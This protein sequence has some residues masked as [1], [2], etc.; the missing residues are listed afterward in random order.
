MQEMLLFEEIRYRYEFP[1][2]YNN[3]SLTCTGGSVD[4][5]LSNVCPGPCCLGATVCTI[6][7]TLHKTADQQAHEELRKRE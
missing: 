1:M 5:S 3:F 2:T 6:Y 4:V 7:K